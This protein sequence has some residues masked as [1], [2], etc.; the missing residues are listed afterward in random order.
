MDEE[1]KQS[2]GEVEIDVSSVYAVKAANAI[3]VVVAAAALVAIGVRE[4]VVRDTEK[5][6][7]IFSQLTR[8]CLKGV[9]EDNGTVGG[10]CKPLDT[11]EMFAWRECVEQG[12]ISKWLSRAF[13]PDDKALASAVQAVEEGK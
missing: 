1:L 4:I 3:I 13:E 2:G 12:K 8:D 9:L 11:G 5:Q 7:A 10:V 6:T